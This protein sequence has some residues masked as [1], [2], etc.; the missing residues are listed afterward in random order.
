[1]F[2]SHLRRQGIVT[3]VIWAVCPP[4]E[5]RALNRINNSSGGITTRGWALHL[6]ECPRWCHPPPPTTHT[7]IHTHMLKEALQQQLP[8]KTHNGTV[9]ELQWIFYCLIQHTKAHTHCRTYGG[10]P[11]IKRHTRSSVQLL[12]EEPCSPFVHATSPSRMAFFLSSA[13][14]LSFLSP[15]SVLSTILMVFVLT[16]QWQCPPL[17]KEVTGAAAINTWM[18]VCL[19]VQDVSPCAVEMECLDVKGYVELS[20][21]RNICLCPSGMSVWLIIPVDQDLQSCSPQL[22]QSD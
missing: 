5:G 4:S 13:L 19:C 18:F 8:R 6:Q 16:K 7:H 12:E 15:P 3:S 22:K 11:P 10:H 9:W 21:C 17:F 2:V 20:A 14:Y 1:M